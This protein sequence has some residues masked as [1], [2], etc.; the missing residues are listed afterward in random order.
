MY[1][2][3]TLDP[4][5][6]EALFQEAYSWIF[7][8]PDWYQYMDGVAS[9][10]GNTYS[11]ENYLKEAKEPTEYNVGLF[12]GKLRAVF[13]IQ[14]QKDGSCQVHVN[15]ENGVDQLALVAGAV[16][17]R[18]WLFANGVVEIFGWLASINRPMK[19]FAEQ[20]GFKYCGVSVFRGSLND[21]PIRWLRFAAMR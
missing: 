10:I 9:V 4:A 16:R 1:I 18:E 14:D 15:A 20:A 2:L 12:N 7:T 8:R 13:T 21:K 3:R 11:F 6:D 19:T 17:L 5:K